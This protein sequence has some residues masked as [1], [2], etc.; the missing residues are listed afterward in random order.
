MAKVLITNLIK[1]TIR[2]AWNEMIRNNPESVIDS[3][4]LFLGLEELTFDDFVES[5]RLELEIADARN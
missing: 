4:T 3:N 1:E 2:P 5:V